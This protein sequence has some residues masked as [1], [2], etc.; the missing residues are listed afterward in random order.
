MLSFEKLTPE[1]REKYEA[2]L[3][4]SE[5]KC[6][7]YSFVNLNVWGR[8]RVA[9]LEGFA[10]LFAQFARFSVYPFPVGSGDLRLPLDAIIQDAAQRGIPCRISS[11]TEKECALLEA[12]YPGKFR[13][14]PDRDDYDYVYA[15][16]DL[17][18][19]KGKRYQSKRN[20]VNRFAAAHPDYRLLPLDDTTVPL[21]RQVAAQWFEERLSQDPQADFLLEKTAL[22]R[23]FSGR[24]VMDL[25][26]LLLMDGDTPLAFAV[27]SR[28]SANTFD[29]HFEKAL[30]IAE[31]A[32]AVINQAFARY[33]REKYPELQYLNREDDM[34]IPGLRKAKLSYH[35]HH[36][37]EKY[38]ARLWE[39]EDAN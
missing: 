35:P 8:Q 25:E 23:T 9:F 17:A 22:E 3:S 18:D 38:W 5:E 7:E 12:L 19:L 28:L 11:M 24:K 1:L 33:L 2:C 34:G 27:G 29:I 20:Y 14:H 15:I 26:G 30:D 32:Y 36:L 13:F 16:D 4:Q 10:L 31:G 21:A 37:V 39:D 6:C